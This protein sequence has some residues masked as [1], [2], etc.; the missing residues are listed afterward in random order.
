[1]KTMRPVAFLVAATLASAALP[2]LGQ[3]ALWRTH[4]DVAYRDA[5]LKA[6]ERKDYARARE[7]FLDA[8]RFSDKGAQAM[9]AELYWFGLGVE[10]D[11]VLAYVWADLAAERGYPVLVAKRESYWKEL[12]AE[13]RARVVEVGEA[14]Y[15]DYGDAV[16]K[17]RLE[18]RLR[19]GQRD[20]TGSRV[21]GPA[22]NLVV[23]N[24][25]Q[26]AGNGFTTNSESHVYAPGHWQPKLYWDRQERA[27]DSVA[28]PAGTVEVLP[29]ESAGE[30]DA[31]GR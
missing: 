5:G 12:D 15:A 4:P 13:Q 27:W 30:K 29:V 16:A 1:M 7:D 31:D 25:V 21:G 19:R 26:P 22:G 24:D 2:A 23:Y 18:K 14:Y 10:R 17:P 6:Y 3:S 11:P 9:L 28:P 20:G 8:A